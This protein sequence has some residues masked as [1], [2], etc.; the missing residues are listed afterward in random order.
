MNKQKRKLIA[1]CLEIFANEF[2]AKKEIDYEDVKKFMERINPLVLKYGHKIVELDGSM[3]HYDRIRVKN[4]VRMLILQEI[5]KH[6]PK[7]VIE[8]LCKKINTLRGHV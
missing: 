3:N 4:Y 8:Y 1:N 7:P 6:F 5:G 2:I